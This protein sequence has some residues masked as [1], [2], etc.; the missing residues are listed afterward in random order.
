MKLLRVGSARSEDIEA[1]LAQ[2]EA[3]CPTSTHAERCRFLRARKNNV[4]A[5]TTLL[6]NHHAWRSKHLPIPATGKRL[7]RG[8][9]KWIFVP[10]GAPRAV[11]GTRVI[12]ALPALCDPQ[13]GTP[14]EYAIA[15]GE[16]LDSQLERGREELWTIVVDVAGV[17]G[18]A[19]ATP[20]ALMKVNRAL[21]SLLSVNFP[22]RL[23]RLVAYPVPG[24]LRHFWHMIKLFLDPATAAKVVLLPGK[25]GDHNRFVAEQLSK[26]VDLQSLPRAPLYGL[27]GADY[28]ATSAG[29]GGA[30]FE[31]HGRI[32]PDVNLADV[33]PRQPAAK[34]AAAFPFVSYAEGE[35]AAREPPLWP[36]VSYAPRTLPDA[37]RGVQQP[38]HQQHQQPSSGDARI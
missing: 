2:M 20:Y 32:P 18:G 31:P 10:P 34:G 35:Y 1:L 25:E 27:E 37:R 11:D 4:K 7:G 15:I 5:A 6:E 3:R 14:E 12:V 24:V 38:V 28:G 23:A 21:A 36:W 9:T 29:D 8:L 13:L 33:R 26:H 30:G 17:S 19:N 22:E 16:L